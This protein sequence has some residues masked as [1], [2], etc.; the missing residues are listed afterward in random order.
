MAEFKTLKQALRSAWTN[1]M[2]YFG[3]HEDSYLELIE[4]TTISQARVIGDLQDGIC[5]DG[6]SHQLITAPMFALCA[7]CEKLFAEEES[8]QQSTKASTVPAKV[9]ADGQM[10][11]EIW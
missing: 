6:D 8:R 2:R 9:N 4:A 10:E 5:R 11:L 1:Q 3:T 7:T